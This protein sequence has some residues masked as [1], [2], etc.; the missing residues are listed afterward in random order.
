MRS[1]DLR[2]VIASLL[3]LLWTERTVQARAT[4]ARLREV[5]SIGFPSAA[6][7]PA[8]TRHQLARET[9]NIWDQQA[10]R[11]EGLDAPAIG[12]YDLHI[13]L[14]TGPTAGEATGPDALAVFSRPN[15]RV[16]LFL[17]VA[18][19]TMRAGMPDDAS[20]NWPVLH[21]HLLLGVVLGRAIA[22]EIGHYLL[23]P[24]HSRRGLMRARFTPVEL[25]D[26]RAGLFGLGRLEAAR[27]ATASL[28]P[29][30]D[31]PD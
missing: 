20:R 25:V 29:A 18:E 9:R 8:A 22:H 26:P 19:R 10:V 23:G 5:V 13:E 17:E 12:P 1:P 7:L 16:T 28:R 21:R 27:L 31:G 30:A 14:V 4:A 2:L 3:A 11:I 24:H 15:R 6:L